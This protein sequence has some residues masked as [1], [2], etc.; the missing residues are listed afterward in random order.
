MQLR[1]DYS[2]RVIWTDMRLQGFIYKKKLRGEETLSE[3]APPENFRIF[4]GSRPNI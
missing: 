1:I 3:H 2:Q 4:E